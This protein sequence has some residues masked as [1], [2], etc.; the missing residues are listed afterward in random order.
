[1]NENFFSKKK[2]GKGKE[3]KKT[4]FKDFLYFFSNNLQAYLPKPNTDSTF[5]HCFSMFEIIPGTR[6]QKGVR[7]AIANLIYFCKHSK[8]KLNT[9]EEIKKS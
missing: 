5:I 6:E 8:L 4:Y 2:K 7:E 1:M 9:A 3:E